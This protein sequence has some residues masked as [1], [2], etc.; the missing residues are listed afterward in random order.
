MSQKDSDAQEMP[1]DGTLDLHTFN[2]KDVKELVP[3]Y[4]EACLEK[5][6]YQLRII[7]GKGTGVLRRIVHSIL[8]KHPAVESFRHESGSGGSWGATVVDLR[9]KPS[10]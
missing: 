8:E 10:D 7:H 1:L 2:P 9:Q 4:I 5:E 6:I 3:D